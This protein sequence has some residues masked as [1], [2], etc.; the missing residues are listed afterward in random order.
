M[1]VAI[2]TPIPVEHCAVLAQ[3]P[4]SLEQIVD[5]NRY[6]SGQFQGKHHSF[7]IITQ[8][9]G[10]KNESIALATEKVIRQFQ[11]L[12]VILAG[13]A[14]GVK[15]VAVGDVVVGTKYYGYEFG[16]VT[17]DGF[18][19]RPESGY[20][21]KELQAV[22][23]SVA[24]NDNWR[25]RAKNAATAKVVFGAIASG[26]KVVAATDSDAYR[27]LKQ[28]YNDTTAIEMEAV[29]FGQAMQS[30][31]AI[32]FLNV[33]GISDLLDGKSKSDATGSQELAAENV[34]A[35]V[36]ELVYQLDVSQFKVFGNM[37]VKELS[38]QI[39]EVVTQADKPGMANHSLQ[40]LL[41]KVQPLI[42]SELGALKNNPNDVDAQ[43][44]ARSELKRALQ[45]KED[46]RKEL[47]GMI[48]KIKKEKAGSNVVIENSKNVIQGSQ[49]SVGGDFHLGDK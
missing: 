21:S 16:K 37:D 41:Q 48:A 26:N 23:Q 32:R 5:G 47:E 17:P 27:L 20:Y 15:D 13:V 34:A 6:L 18:V 33:R 39:V 45:G 44:D 22:A 4:H 12:V 46:L 29:G 3:L 40:T 30:Y 11:P 7:H 24:D 49:I 35:F 10:S 38:R 8:Q 9:A 28:T 1:N 43:A 14:G 19:T 31:P 36:F 42:P 25:R 2:L